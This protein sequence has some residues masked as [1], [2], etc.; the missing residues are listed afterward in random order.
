RRRRPTRSRPTRRSSRSRPQRSP[1]PAALSRRGKKPL[2]PGVSV[3]FAHDARATK[4]GAMSDASEQEAVP[5]AGEMVEM[6]VAPA[7]ADTPAAAEAEGLTPAQRKGTIAGLMVTLFLA[8]L[9]QTV[10]GT[11]MPRVIADLH[12][13][14]RYAWVTTGYLLTTTLT[15]PIVARLSDLYGR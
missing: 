7:E 8:A 1:A 2:R 5:L 10:V 12:G 3:C 14:E 4:G 11:A 13:F 15:V 6:P 9:D